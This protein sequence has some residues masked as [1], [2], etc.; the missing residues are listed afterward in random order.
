MKWWVD[1][2]VAGRLSSGGKILKWWVDT[3]VVGR[4]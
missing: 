3:E 1:I 4:Y 2:E